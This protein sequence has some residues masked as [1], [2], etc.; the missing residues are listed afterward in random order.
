MSFEVRDAQTAY[1][2]LGDAGVPTVSEPVEFDDCTAFV[3]AD[4]DGHSIDRRVISSASPHPTKILRSLH[5]AYPS[6]AVS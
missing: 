2:A 6:P 3:I 5:A 1:R 4:P